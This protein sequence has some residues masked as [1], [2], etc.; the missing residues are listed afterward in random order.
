VLTDSVVRVSNLSQ[1]QMDEQ[2]M[3]AFR[4][5]QQQQ[6]GAGAYLPITSVNAGPNLAQSRTQSAGHSRLA[7][8]K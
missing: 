6:A 5:W 2:E 7:E 4:M 1:K 8:A 3:G